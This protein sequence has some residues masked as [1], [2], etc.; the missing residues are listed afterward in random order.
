MSQTFQDY[1]S[2][3][4]QAYTT[5][6]NNYD[7]VVMDP[8]SRFL[9]ESRTDSERK[10]WRKKIDE[11]LDERLRMMEVRDSFKNLDQSSEEVSPA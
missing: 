9:S 3:P 8:L 11:S 4:Y 1:I 10:Y 5:L 2:N 6:I 7:K